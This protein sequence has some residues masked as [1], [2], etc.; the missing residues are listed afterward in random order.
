MPTNLNALIRYKAIDTCLKNKYIR[1]TIPRLREACSEVLGEKRGIYKKV[2]KRT[3]QDDIRVLRSD[4]LGFNAPIEVQD[5]V[6]FYSDENYSIFNIPFN[7]EDILRDVLA[8]LTR[9]GRF[10]KDEEL[11]SL[12]I[13]IAELLGDNVSKY[14]PSKEYIDVTGTEEFK[15]IGNKV[16]EDLDIRF[17]YADITRDDDIIKSGISWNDIL[18]VL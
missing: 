14:S 5:G 13:R 7:Q 1:C 4:I 11:E 12:V 6:Y 17:C 8:I 18:S 3:I 16:H 2:G 15:V 10:S 9:D